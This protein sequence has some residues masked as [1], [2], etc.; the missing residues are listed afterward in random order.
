MPIVSTARD[1]GIT[2]TSSL[3]PSAHVSDIVSRAHKRASAIHR[4]FVSRDVRLLVRAFKVY[5]RPLLE[6]NS[7]IWSPNTLKVD[8]IECVQRRFTKRLHGFYNYSYKSRLKYLDLQSLELRRLIVDLIWCYKIVFGL[9][10][11][12]VNDF[13]CSELCT[14]YPR[15]CV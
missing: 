9:V 8:S 3:S 10:D 6:H 7:V 2:V 12:D 13:F 14:S 11:I 5:V 4:C 15:A 1:L